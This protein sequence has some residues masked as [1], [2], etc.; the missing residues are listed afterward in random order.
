MEHQLF[1]ELSWNDLDDW[2]GNKVL[3]RGK[4]YKSDV[5]DLAS[6]K[7]NHV[8]ATV[9]GTSTYLTE[10]WF[11]DED[12]QSSCT[13]P[14]DWGIHCKHAV[15]VILVLLDKIRTNKPIPNAEDVPSARSRKL[16]T[17]SE[18]ST[19]E[20]FG[21]FDI[22]KV[23]VALSKIKKEELVAWCAELIVSSSNLDVN[24]PGGIEPKTLLPD[25]ANVTNQQVT[26]ILDGILY[27]TSLRYYESE[28]GY[29]EED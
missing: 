14:Y 1:R 27:E 11:D 19:E 5:E 16:S 2:V 18:S 13:C 22:K 20:D 9:H 15:A 26:Q 24:L 29:G 21:Q 17:T 25:K 12:L 28:W 4:S 6:V 8:V 10:V 23:R 7:D 3:N